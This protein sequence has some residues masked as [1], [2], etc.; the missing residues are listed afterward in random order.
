MHAFLHAIGWKALTTGDLFLIGCIGGA[1]F[2]ILAW[3][4]DVLLERISF[5]VILNTLILIAGAVLGLFLLVQIDMAPTQKHYMHAVFACGVS[6][7]LLL[8]AL[9]SM[10]RAV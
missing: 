4:A 6:A 2:L 3:F 1:I 10:R 5:G 7:V 8:V 9:A